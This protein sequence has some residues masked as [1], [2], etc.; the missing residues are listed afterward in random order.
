MYFM[1]L[2]YLYGNGIEQNVEKAADLFHRLIHSFAAEY[3]QKD[4]S[5]AIQ[6]LMESAE[7]GNWKRH[8]KR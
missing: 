3:V 7:L 8:S 4:G 6:K 5:S 2:C 1:G